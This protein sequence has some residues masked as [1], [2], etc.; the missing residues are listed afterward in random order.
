M[1]VLIL[2]Y[3]NKLLYINC[4]SLFVT[5]I[6][7]FY[8]VNINTFNCCTVGTCEIVYYVHHVKSYSPNVFTFFSIFSS[9]GSKYVHTVL[10]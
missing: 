3:N 4:F 10:Y 9:T 8:L 6:S 5:T 2:C 1:G 7:K